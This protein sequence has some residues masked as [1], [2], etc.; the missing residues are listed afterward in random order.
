MSEDAPNLNPAEVVELGYDPETIRVAGVIGV[1]EKH[2]QGE[3]FEQAF[4]DWHIRMEKLADVKNDGPE[5]TFAR[6]E[7]SMFEVQIFF[8]IGDIDSAAG[9]FK[10]AHAMI[11]NDDNLRPSPESR[12]SYSMIMELRDNIN[13]LHEKL[14]DAGAEL[15]GYDYFE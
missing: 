12:I 13:Y 10:A 4:R 3:K 7:M 8:E 6:V 2:G 14:E 1:F 9:S 15:D 11:E 5:R